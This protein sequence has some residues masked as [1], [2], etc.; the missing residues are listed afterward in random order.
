[1]Y[2]KTFLLMI[3]LFFSFPAFAVHDE[4][5]KAN[6]IQGS[7]ER[8]KEC[9]NNSCSKC[10]DYACYLDYNDTLQEVFDEDDDFNLYNLDNFNISECD[11]APWK[12]KNDN[13]GRCKIETHKTIDTTGMPPWK[14]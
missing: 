5:F 1:M 12:R 3:V 6:F 14:K 9:I 10:Q 7:Q 4:Q 8:L 2:K 13:N 11:L